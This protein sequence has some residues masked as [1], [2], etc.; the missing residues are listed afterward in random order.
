MTTE[1]L[2]QKMQWHVE[3][4]VKHYK[5]DFDIDKDDILERI[6]S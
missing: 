1:E 3:R 4:E 2:F 6:A 5:T